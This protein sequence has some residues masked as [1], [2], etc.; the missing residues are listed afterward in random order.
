MGRFRFGRNLASTRAVNLEKRGIELVAVIST[1]PRAGSRPPK[2]S[3][4]K[5]GPFTGPW[6][7]LTAAVFGQEC[8]I[9]LKEQFCVSF[10]AGWAFFATASSFEPRFQPRRGAGVRANSAARYGL[11]TGARLKSLY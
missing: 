5:G 10:L 8:L 4:A 9:K 2:A 11:A 6:L 7:M 3:S 1:A